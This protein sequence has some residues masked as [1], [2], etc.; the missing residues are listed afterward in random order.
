MQN[1]YKLN[2]SKYSTHKIIIDMIGSNK[3]ILDIGC[4]EGYI[5]EQSDK[6]N[7]FYGIDYS[8]TALS[9]ASK[10]YKHVE[11][12]DLNNPT[13]P[14][15]KSVKFDVILFADVLEHLTEPEKVLRFF[16]SYL[17]DEG[18]IIISLPNVANWQIRIN[19]LLGNF[20]YTDS[21]ILDRTHYHL[22]TFDTA[23][24]LI[25]NCNLEMVELRGGAS[26]FGPIISLFPFL[27]SLLSTGIIV[28]C[29]KK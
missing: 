21:G 7:E 3:K 5:G 25:K 14:S 16:T 6:T 4:N 20:N 8:E 2:L 10:I 22:Y 1:N 29:K 19:L 26:V 9:K 24:E 15:L 23:L 17:D 12:M 18:F 11:L 28:K 27:K 13:E